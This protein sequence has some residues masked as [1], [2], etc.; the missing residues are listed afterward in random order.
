MIRKFFKSNKQNF[1]IRDG[2]ISVIDARSLE[3]DR[4]KSIAESKSIFNLDYSEDPALKQMLRTK[5]MMIKS[6]K[7]A[8]KQNSSR[9]IS[10][11]YDPNSTSKI[12]KVKKTK[13]KI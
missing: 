11:K 1:K 6:Q 3:K 10:P 12:F 7:S 4:K 9:S 13:L 8:N 5:A 2:K